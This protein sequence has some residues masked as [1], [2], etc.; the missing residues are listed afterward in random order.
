MHGVPTGEAT[1][2]GMITGKG[3]AE[4]QDFSYAE[5]FADLPILA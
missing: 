4:K 3:D 5:N 2:C 1:R